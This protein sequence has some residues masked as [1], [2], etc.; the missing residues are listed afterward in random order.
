MCLTQGMQA[1]DMRRFE[2]VVYAR[3]RVKRGEALF[4]AGDEFKSVHAVRSGAMKLRTII[5]NRAALRR[6][7]HDAA[8]LV[9]VVVALPTPSVPCASWMT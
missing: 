4:G 6:L 3:R 7:L 1:D 5:F 9:K 2:N 8:A